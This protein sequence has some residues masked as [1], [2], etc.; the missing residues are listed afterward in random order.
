MA[1]TRTHYVCQNCG[2]SSP[3]F[4][5]RC[6]NCGKWNSLV[7]EVDQG[8]LEKT[9]QPTTTLTGIVAKR[10]KIKEIDTQKTSRV[11]TRLNELNRVLGGGIVPG[12][13]VLIGGSG[14]REVDLAA[15]SLRPTERGRP[16]G[17]LRVRKKVPTKSRCGP[18]GWPCRGIISTFTR[19]PTWTASG[20]RSTI[21]NLNT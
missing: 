7:E 13:L 2:Y 4:L 6:P 5:G 3:R 8:Q 1:K 21:S 12:S 9:V 10:Q 19:K 17:P 20:P 11:K 18:N 15:A 16:L 14:D